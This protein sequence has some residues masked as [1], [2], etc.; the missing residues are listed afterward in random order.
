MASELLT[1]SLIRR[2]RKGY[3]IKP[4]SEPSDLRSSYLDPCEVNQLAIMKKWRLSW[5]PTQV[6]KKSKMPTVAQQVQRHGWKATLQIEATRVWKE[7]KSLGVK[8]VL[9]RIAEQLYQFALKH[10]IRGDHGKTPTAG[11][12]R[13]HVISLK[14]WTR[15]L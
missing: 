10:Q 14:A 3:P 4:W 11:Y 8:P 13:T 15:P 1:G 5:S 12:I 2:N 9:K 6:V 7:Q